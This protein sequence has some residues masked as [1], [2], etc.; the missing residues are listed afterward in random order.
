MTVV[1]VT[2]TVQLYGTVS[3]ILYVTVFNVP[4]LQSDNYYSDYF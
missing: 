4:T 1:I 3:L 2:G